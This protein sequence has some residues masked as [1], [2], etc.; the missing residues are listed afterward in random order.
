M[1]VK[2]GSL[3]SSR[4]SGHTFHPFSIRH[5]QIWSNVPLWYTELEADINYIKE[6]IIPLE[7]IAN[8]TVT[9]KDYAFA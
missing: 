1:E 3:G 2:D 9:W 8:F 4:S 5:V 7:F 6:G